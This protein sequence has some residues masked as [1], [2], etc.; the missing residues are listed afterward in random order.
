MARELEVN[1]LNVDGGTVDR[2]PEEFDEFEPLKLHWK[3]PGMVYRWCDR[4]ARVL[5]VRRR[6][7]WKICNVEKDFRELGCPELRIPGVPQPGGEIHFG[8]SI[9]AEMPIE[10][11]E[12]RYDSMIRKAT[13][14]SARGLSD[15]MRAG[16]EVAAELRSRG[17]TL[18]KPLVSE[19]DVAEER[20][21]WN[22]DYKVQTRTGEI[23]K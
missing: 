1:I 15:V 10:L 22:R 19:V 6:Q 14:R 5:P 12:K 16:D 9:L 11:Y 21:D 8:D 23:V 7:G 13:E 17:V 20:R 2:P 4:D 18:T 3:K